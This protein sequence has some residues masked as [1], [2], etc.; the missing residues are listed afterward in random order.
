MS[1]LEANALQAVTPAWVENLKS[2]FY[3]GGLVLAWI[4]PVGF[5]LVARGQPR[6]NP[7]S[8][9]GMFPLNIHTSS[10]NT[11]TLTPTVVTTDLRTTT[12]TGPTQQLLENGH[13]G[14]Y[15]S[16]EGVPHRDGGCK[17][18]GHA[19]YVRFGDA[20]VPGLSKRTPA[21]LDPSPA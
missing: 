21:L 9:P 8:S 20:V 6:R 16:P 1:N 15:P 17:D 7:E 3:S 18:A 11:P 12:N 5:F 13:A 4:S 14:V 19:E 10:V 2:A